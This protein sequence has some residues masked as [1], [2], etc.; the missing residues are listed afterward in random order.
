MQIAVH[1]D[2]LGDRASKLALSQKRAEMVMA[3]L[4]DAGIDGA[5]LT[6]RGYGATRPIA[7]DDTSEGRGQN[8]R[9]EF[10]VMEKNTE[11]NEGGRAL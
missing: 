1:T 8:R 5:R 7:P 11:A 6:A 4:L 10:L 9:V 3:H 2:G